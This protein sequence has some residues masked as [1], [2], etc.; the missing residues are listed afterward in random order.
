VF[1]VIAVLSHS[2]LDFVGSGAIRPTVTDGYSIYMYVNV[3]SVRMSGWSS[4][5]RAT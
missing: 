4:M 3:K 5:T 2:L 1:L